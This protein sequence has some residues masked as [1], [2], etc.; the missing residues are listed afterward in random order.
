MDKDILAVRGNDVYV[1]YNHSQTVWCSSSHD[2]GQSWTSVKVNQNAQFGWSLTGG[3]TVDPAGN[4]YFSWNGYTQNG[5]AKG[6]VNLYVTKSV[7]G[8]LTWTSKLLDISAAPPDCSAFQCGWAFLGPGIAMTSDA[9]GQLYVLWN[10]GAADGGPERMYFSTSTD[11][12][13]TWSSRRDVSLAPQGVDHAFPAL[14]AGVAGDIRIAWMDQRAEPYWNVYYRSSTDGGAT[15]TAETKLSTFVKGYSYIFN[16]GFR[17]PFGD[18]FDMTI[19][20]LRG[21]L[22]LFCRVLFPDITTFSRTG[23]D[24]PLAIISIWTSTT[25][26]I[27]RWLGARDTIG[28]HRGMCGIRGS[29]GEVQRFARLRRGRQ[30]SDDR[31]LTST[32]AVRRLR[33]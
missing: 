32:L 27:R 6:P 18:Y 10:S 20:Y 9:A 22:K 28:S 16:T 13:T 23:S 25:S 15:W 1:A 29:C 21:P 17:F 5:G 26:R 7:D 14:A 4:V 19:D 31:V 12:S 33:R 3:G 8:G 2:G 24:F 30:F 11:Q